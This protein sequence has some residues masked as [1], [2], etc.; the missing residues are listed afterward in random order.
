MLERG[1]DFHPRRDLSDPKHKASN[2]H[3]LLVPAQVL[4]DQLTV[5][6]IQV[7][8]ESPRLRRIRF[9]LDHG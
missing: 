1:S 4:S 3:A 2:K 9:L 7:L 5:D 6:N 8:L